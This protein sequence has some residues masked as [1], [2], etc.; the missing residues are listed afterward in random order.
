MRD[1]QRSVVNVLRLKVLQQGRLV[2]LMHAGEIE[3]CGD[4]NLE[5]SHRFSLGKARC[6]D[7][8]WK[9]A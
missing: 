7:V 2:T 8:K 3:I 4:W 9:S 5:L 1:V 6:E